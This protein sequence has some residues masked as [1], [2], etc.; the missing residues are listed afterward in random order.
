MPASVATT[1]ISFGKATVML[2]TCVVPLPIKPI[3]VATGVAD[4]A[5]TRLMEYS[6]V[7]SSASSVKAANARP[8]PPPGA[9][10]KPPSFVWFRLNPNGRQGR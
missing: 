5:V 6:R 2:R 4:T 9:M 1:S 8:R 7:R 3:E 10:S